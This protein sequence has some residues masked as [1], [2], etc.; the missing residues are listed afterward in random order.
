[1]QPYDL[2]LMDAHVAP[3]QDLRRFRWLGN[4]IEAERPRRIITVGDM[5][6][7]DS[8]SDHDPPGSSR[9]RKRPNF[10]Q[11]RDSWREAQRLMFGPLNRWNAGQRSHRHASWMPE[12]HYIKGNHEQRFDRRADKDVDVVGSVVDFDEQMSLDI[13]D[14]VH[15]YKRYVNIGGINYTHVPHNKMGRP[16][17]GVQ[18]GRT[19]CQHS[20]R[21][22]IFGHTHTM[23]FTSLALLGSRNA[24]RCALNGPA[25]M[26]QGNVE[27]YAKDTQTGWVY[28]LL[29]VRAPTD[30]DQAFSFDFLSMEDLQ[31]QYS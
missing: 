10:K 24:V 31:C 4:L 1:M 5:S 30:P 13:W 22:V 27:P 16:I 3:G 21:H 20:S 6:T 15:P 19:V 25:F 9:D 11:D 7:L 14:E 28:G 8:C 12:L 29:R 18:A 2:V 26:E 17:T 23:N